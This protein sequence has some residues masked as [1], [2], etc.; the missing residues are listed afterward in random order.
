MCDIIC[1]S[2]ALGDAHIAPFIR[3]L[4]HTHAAEINLAACPFFI[5]ACDG[6]WDALTDQEAVDAVMRHAPDYAHGAAAL[7]DLAFLHGST[8]NISAMVIDLARLSSALDA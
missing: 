6:V 4:A 5:V 7:R 2:R 3:P 8:D 1:P